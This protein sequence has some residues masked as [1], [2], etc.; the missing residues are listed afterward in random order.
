MLVIGLGNKARHGKDYAGHKI[1]MQAMSMGMGARVY[2]FADALRAYC[3]VAFGMR[4][5]DVRLLQYV[6]T[7]IFR[8]KDPDVWVRV[9]LDTIQEQNPDVAIITDMRFPNEASAIRQQKGYTVRIN[10]ILPDGSP[11]VSD[12]R[13]PNH[14]SET[15]LDD[16][17]FD[18][19]INAVSGDVWGLTSKATRL[20]DDIVRH[21]REREAT[22]ANIRV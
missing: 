14:Q 11:W 19:T 4:E 9:L 16:Y 7:E 22:C 13:D 2:G 10:R 21:H 20:F 17:L 6:G 12:D 3:R 18:Y 1:A 5:K 15:A 8:K